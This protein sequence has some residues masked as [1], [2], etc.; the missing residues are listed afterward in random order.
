MRSKKELD[1]SGIKY[2]ELK[3]WISGK[4][5]VSTCM[6]SSDYE[7]MDYTTYLSKMASMLNFEHCMESDRCYAEMKFEV[8]RRKWHDRWL[9]NL[10]EQEDK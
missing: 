2:K 9:I 5:K 1:E 3:R 7:D 10:V 4:Y 8:I 6:F